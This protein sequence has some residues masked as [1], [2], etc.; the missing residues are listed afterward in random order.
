MS[1]STNW[2]RTWERGEQT[3]R[4]RCCAWRKNYNFWSKP[5][6]RRGANAKGN[7]KTSNGRTATN[8]IASP[9]VFP[10]VSDYGVRRLNF[11]VV[12]FRYGFGWIGWI[13]FI[14]WHLFETIWFMIICCVLLLLT[15]WF[16][17]YLQ[18]QNLHQRIW[19]RKI[20]KN[21]FI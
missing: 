9:Y 15:T 12:Y 4:H 8:A 14:L 1:A 6:R 2:W 10:I 19:L 7:T 3:E 13:L 11:I 5:K 20:F 18:Y 21:N 16:L 17:F